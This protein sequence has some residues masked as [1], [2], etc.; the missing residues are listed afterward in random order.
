M[1]SGYGTAKETIGV[2]AEKV[3]F[4]L[5]EMRRKLSDNAKS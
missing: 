3:G 4:D 2:R 5:D 1:D